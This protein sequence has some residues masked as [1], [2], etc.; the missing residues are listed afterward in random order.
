MRV[1]IKVS[2]LFQNCFDVVK[3]FLW[4]IVCVSENSFDK[5]ILI[6]GILLVSFVKNKS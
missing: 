2:L 1:I 6:R 5:N 3:V 4:D